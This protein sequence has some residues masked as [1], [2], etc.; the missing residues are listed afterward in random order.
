LNELADR[1]PPHIV[2]LWASD[3][4][5]RFTGLWFVCPN[6]EDQAAHFKEWIVLPT[7]EEIAAQQMDFNQEPASDLGMKKKAQSGEV[8][9]TGTD[10]NP[11]E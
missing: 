3:E 10:N 8:E 1:E 11:K 7:L 6:G 9:R 5:G 4:E 2:L